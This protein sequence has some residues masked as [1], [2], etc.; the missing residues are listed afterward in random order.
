MQVVSEEYFTGVGLDPNPLYAGRSIDNPQI[1][2]MLAQPAF[3]TFGISAKLD[4]RNAVGIDSVGRAGSPRIILRR[5]VPLDEE[6]QAGTKRHLQPKKPPAEL[7]SVRSHPRHRHRHQVEAPTEADDVDRAEADSGQRIGKGVRPDP[8]TERAVGCLGRVHDRDQL[9]VVRAKRNKSIRGTVAGVTATGHRVEPVLVQQ[10]LRGA[11]EVG[12]RQDRMIESQHAPDAT[13]PG[14]GEV[15][16]DARRGE[17][18]R[19][20]DTSKGGE[21]RCGRL[22]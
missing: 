20:V 15:R 13:P 21:H 10:P 3:Q 12:N 16:I 7:D 9:E 17:Q 8:P 14:S 18:R 6:R 4:P 19:R 5:N 1:Q 22:P 11:I 2:V